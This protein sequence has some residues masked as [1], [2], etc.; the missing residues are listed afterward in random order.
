MMMWMMMMMMHDQGLYVVQQGQVPLIISWCPWIW[1]HNEL[2]ALSSFHL[3]N[4][5]VAVNPQRYGNRTAGRFL[6][7]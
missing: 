5:R 7:G 2:G 3:I 6:N 4:S 1:K